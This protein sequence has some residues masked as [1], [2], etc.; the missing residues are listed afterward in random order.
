MPKEEPKP[1]PKEEPKPVPKE[2]PKPVHKE[3]PK[4]APDVLCGR[5]LKSPQDLTGFPTFPAGT[6]S[7]LSKNLTRE[8]W[9]KYHDAKDKFG[10]SFKEAIFS[11][12]QNTD[13]SVG[14]YLGTKDSY[15]AF[16]DF[17]EKIVEQ[18]HGVKQHVKEI[19]MDASKLHAPALHADEQA[20]IVSTRIRVGR[21]LDDYALGPAIKDNER[22]EIEAKVSKGLQSLTGDLAGTYYP[23]NN[24]T[25]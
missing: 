2:E 15:R 21:N 14:V 9:A 23:L 10:F 19:H 25:E 12:C 5:H 17:A 11:G 22:K 3:E 18:Y 7:L 6:N 24:L 1:V 8:I 13:S 16:Q 20:M 4:P